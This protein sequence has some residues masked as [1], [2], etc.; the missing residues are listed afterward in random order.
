MA[1]VTGVHHHRST[2][3]ASNKPFKSRK[4]TK[5]SIKELAKGSNLF[6]RL[7]LGTNNF[8]SFVLR[9]SRGTRQELS[10]LS[11]STAHV[12]ARPAK[13]SASETAA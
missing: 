9:Q 3:K 6:I 2:T 4:A 13:S 1:A 12:Q 11:P 7:E 5:G 10:S 8:T